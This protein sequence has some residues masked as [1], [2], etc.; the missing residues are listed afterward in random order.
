LEYADDKVTDDTLMVDGKEYKSE[1]WNFPRITTTRWSNKNDTLIIVSKVVFNRGGET[2]EMIS[3]EYWTL[4]E[5]GAIL[6]IAQSSNSPW[7]K[8]NITVMYDRR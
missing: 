6:S 2:S 8:R 3:N 5:H 7:G 1:M 4:Q